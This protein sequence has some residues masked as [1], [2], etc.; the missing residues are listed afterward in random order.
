ME[1]EIP[2]G[3]PSFEELSATLNDARRL[4]RLMVARSVGWRYEG[5]KAD[6][7][8]EREMWREINANEM[9]ES[10][11]VLPPKYFRGGFAVSEAYDSNSK[12]IVYACIVTVGK[13]YFMRLCTINEAVEDAATLRSLLT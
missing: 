6:Y 3:K 5:C 11:E 4:G 1:Y 8:A 9:Q 13:R 7:L 10:L 12:G 2:R